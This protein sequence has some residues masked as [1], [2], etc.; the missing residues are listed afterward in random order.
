MKLPNSPPTT[1]TDAASTISR[2]RPAGGSG[3]FNEERFHGK[4]D[5]L[6]PAEVEAAYY[7]VSLSPTG[8]RNQTDE[9]M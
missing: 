5:D 3:W 6:T 7:F 9:H 4:L 8:M 1:A 2:S